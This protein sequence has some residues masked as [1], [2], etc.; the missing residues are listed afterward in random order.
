VI[1]HK[2]R[3]VAKGYVQKQGIDFEEVFA[4]VARIESVRLLLALAANEGWP[5]HHMDV[6]SAFLNGELEEEVYVA[7][8][9]G[10]VVTGEEGKVFRLRKALYGLRQAP[11]AWNAKLDATMTSL[12]FQRSKS[13]HAMYA[14]RNLLVGVYVDDLVIT[15]SSIDEIQCFKAEMKNTF[16]MSDLGLLSYYLGIEVRQNASGIMLAQ[17]AYARTILEKAGMEDCNACH[18]PMEARLKLSKTSTAQPVDATKYR[19][20]VGSLQ[21][22]VHMRPDISFAVGYVSRF[23]KHPTEEHWNAVKHILRYIA[24]TLDYGCSYKGAQGEGAV[25]SGF[26][27][28][29]MAG[30][31]DSRK[32]TTG[33]LFFL[34][35]RPVSWQSQKQKVVALSS[36]EAEYIAATTTACQGIWLTRLLGDFTGEGPKAA[37]L[38]VD[39]KSTISLIKNP[40]D[41]DRSKHI[42]LRFHF[43]RECVEKKQI[44]VEFI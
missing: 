38:R 5:V 1:K 22:L 13:E 35:D 17:S 34:G 6:K 16:R 10:F 19:S 26:S 14:R 15:G 4:P 44:L 8:A 42:D 12:G 43:I 9:P 36:C 39:N 21:Y 37:K 20:I 28:S 33:V 2:A 30:D 40:V 29:D 41:H 32:S 11:R 3:L 25:L 18:A 23:M 24:G 7:Q 27:D 31:V